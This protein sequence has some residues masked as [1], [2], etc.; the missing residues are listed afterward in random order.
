MCEPY[1]TTE[2][3]VFDITEATFKHT[4]NFRLCVQ[5]VF[6]TFTRM[7]TASLKQGKFTVMNFAC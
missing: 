4:K 7:L 6:T 1:T 2:D 3:T 5:H